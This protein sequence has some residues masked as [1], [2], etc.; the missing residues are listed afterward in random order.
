MTIDQQLLIL[1]FQILAGILMG[2]DYL[3]PESWRKNLNDQTSIR[4]LNVQEG[5]DLDIL[6]AWEHAKNNIVVI[7]VSILMIFS[8]ILMI[9]FTDFLIFEGK[10]IL[11][12]LWIVSIVVLFFMGFATL[13]NVSAD[14][15]VPIGLGGSLR[16]FTTLILA[17]PK[18]PLAAIGFLCLC[19]S[20]IL[21]YK[22][23][24]T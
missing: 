22:Y 12:A 5:I 9:Y 23:L 14:I 6:K 7:V 11:I 2:L 8:S 13:L 3:M 15:I 17:S 1:N 4:I 16:V 19:T 24:S 21:R 18:G 20:F 10:Y